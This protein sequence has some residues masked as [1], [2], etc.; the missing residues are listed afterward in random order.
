M[1]ITSSVFEDGGII[2]PQ[3]TCDGNSRLSP[4]L[5]FSDVPEGA[6]SLVLIVDDP[7][8]PKVLMPEGV[9]DHWV[10]YNIPPETR[11]IP[12]GESAG[13]PGVNTRGEPRYTGPCPPPEYEPSTHRYIFTLYAL[14]TTL[15]LA[16]GA[17]KEEV[18]KALE[19]R[20][21]ET[22]RLTGMYS[23]KK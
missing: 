9:F 6:R 19:G 22:A 10:L 14:D 7:D 23:R 15:A 16:E 20:V 2:P 17:T 13:T 21:L 18:L 4:P 12:E 8:V 3:Y 5:S 11:E 1:K